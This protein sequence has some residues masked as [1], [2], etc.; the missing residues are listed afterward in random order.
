MKKISSNISPFLL[1]VI[2]IVVILLGVSGQ[3]GQEV[4]EE[5][6]HLNASFISLSD[7]GIFKVLL[8][9]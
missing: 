1:L 4:I 5:R 2:P 6:I 8:W 3:T 7:T 9:R